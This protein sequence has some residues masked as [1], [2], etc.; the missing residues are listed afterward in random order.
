MYERQESITLYRVWVSIH[1]L[2][3]ERKKYY[4]KKMIIVKFENS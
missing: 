4:D 1:W 3:A 2:R